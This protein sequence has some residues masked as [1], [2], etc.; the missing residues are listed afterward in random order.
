MRGETIYQYTI[1]L[2]GTVDFGLDL[3][4]VLSGEVPIPPQGARFDAGFEGRSSGRIAGRIR[5]IDHAYL[6][7]DGR[8]ELNLRAVFETDDGARIA[9]CGDGVGILRPDAPVLDLS[10]NIS[11]LTASPSYAWVNGPQIWAVGF[12]DLA[13]GKVHLESFMQ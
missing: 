8:F 6:R 7:P 12:A 13:A 10:E 11:L 9:L 3:N 1:D 2:T 4:A 5:G